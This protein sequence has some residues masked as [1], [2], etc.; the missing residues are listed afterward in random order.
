MLLCSLL[1]VATCPIINPLLCFFAHCHVKTSSFSEGLCF[2]RPLLSSLCQLL[3][4]L[5]FTTTSHVSL[6]NCQIL[7]HHL[8]LFNS[9]TFFSLFHFCCV[10]PDSFPPVSLPQLLLFSSL[11]IFSF[12]FFLFLNFSFF[13]SPLLFL[14]LYSFSSIPFLFLLLYSFASVHIL[15]HIN[16]LFFS[17]FCLIFCALIFRTV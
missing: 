16:I 17:L 12:P 5:I 15:F 8:I 9:I 13:T 11:S 10:R 14:L 7:P 3:Q 6:S 1:C 2:T 4:F